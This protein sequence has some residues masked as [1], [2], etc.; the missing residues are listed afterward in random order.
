MPSL[1]RPRRGIDAMCCGR[2][3][4]APCRHPWGT[5]L[6][7]ID[8]NGAAVDHIKLTREEF[9]PR[10]AF[11]AAR[12]WLEDADARVSALRPFQVRALRPCI[13]TTLALAAF[14]PIAE[15]ARRKLI[16]HFLRA[17]IAAAALGKD[18]CS[19]VSTNCTRG[20]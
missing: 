11:R 14:A 1:G 7:L 19:R 2:P 15:K 4:Q 16:R 5:D 13:L 10:R 6:D 8:R 12:S 20:T 9:A 17:A 18:P 3:C